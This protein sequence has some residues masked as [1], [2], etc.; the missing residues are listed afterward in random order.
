M[1]SLLYY[2]MFNVQN[3]D[4]SKPLISK[5]YDTLH[6]HGPTELPHKEMTMAQSAVNILTF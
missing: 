4:I 1:N 3:R 5:H 6:S 2:A